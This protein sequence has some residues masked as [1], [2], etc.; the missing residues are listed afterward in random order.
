MGKH[1]MV[2]RR[3]FLWTVLVVPL[4]LFALACG[5]AEEPTATATSPS[6]AVATPTPAMDPTP[7]PVGGVPK[8]GG[9]LTMVGGQLTHWDPTQLCCP[10]H[11]Q[12]VGKLYKT[13]L[14]EEGQDNFSCDLCVDWYLE[15]GGTTMVWELRDDIK[16]HDGTPITANDL[17]Y[18][19][20][21]LTGNIDGITNIRMGYIKSYIESTEAVDNRTFKVHFTRATPVAAITFAQQLS[22]ILPEGTARKDL[23]EPPLGPNSKYTSGPYYVKES[24]PDSHQIFAKFPDYFKDGLPYI[25]EIRN[26]VFVD[27]AARMT[28]LLTGKA[29]I[30]QGLDAGVPQFWGQLE[31]RV[32]MGTMGSISKPLYCSIGNM[33][34]NFDVPVMQDKRVRQAID[35]SMNRDEYGTL[36]YGGRYVAAVY[37]FPAN[38]FYGRPDTEIWNVIPGWGRGA[39]K[40]AEIEEAKKL[41]ADAGYPEGTLRLEIVSGYTGISGKGREAYQN[42]MIAAGIDAVIDFDRTRS[43][44][45]A[46]GD[47]T[48]MDARNCLASGDPDEVHANYHIPG[49][50]RNLHNYENQE[51][52]DL[53]QQITSEVDLA[54]RRQIN[55]QMVDILIEDVES[56]QLGDGSQTYWFN[57]K[58]RGITPGKTIYGTS[59][60]N[61]ETWWLDQ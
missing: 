22:A 9:T 12:I 16:F 41:L 46:A 17:V 21:K 1:I 55:D 27:A 2:S 31:A 54:K 60:H 33:W 35:L 39:T 56:F 5:A 13:F 26:Q 11:L 44:R 37:G 14:L 4:L 19:L 20:D 3:L 49:G 29:D 61:P 59:D 10:T 53:F 7:T 36:R 43:Q 28:A 8:A 15:D 24:V 34:P 23:Q 42:G 25:D 58:L 38:T 18:S 47:Y 48:L 30:Y 57:S 51:I 6:G 32:Q 50:P 45:W 40:V 52:T